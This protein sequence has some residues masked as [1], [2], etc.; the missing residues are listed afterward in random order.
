MEQF[1][2][3][4]TDQRGSHLLR[5]ADA[6][7]YGVIECFLRVQP[8]DHLAVYSDGIYHHGIVL[9]RPAEDVS[10]W[11]VAD[12][13]SPSNDV[14]MRDAALRERLVTEF[15]HG[16]SEFWIVPYRDILPERLACARACA[17]RMA[18]KA[19]ELELHKLAPYHCLHN[20]CQAFVVLCKYGV[21][22]NRD[23]DS[24][25]QTIIDTIA[26]DLR[27]GRDGVLYQMYEAAVGLGMFAAFQT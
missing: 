4:L 11:L 8:G 27:R 5:P 13:S 10:K 3:L 20:N 2:A 22:G 6:T 9:E 17:V 1:L 21:G 16:C 12:F 24:E 7:R 14:R 23:T 26:R 25:A 15:V 19:V 18:H